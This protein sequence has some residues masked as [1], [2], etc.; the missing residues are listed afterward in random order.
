MKI[1]PEAIVYSITMLDLLRAIERRI[2]K[3]ESSTLSE[4]DL[5]LAKEEVVAVIE[6]MNISVLDEALDAWEI[7]RNL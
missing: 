6:H 4:N 2:G 5:A 3:E 7:T 1:D